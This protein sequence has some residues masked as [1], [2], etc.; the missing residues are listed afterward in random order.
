MKDIGEKC[1]N[2]SM[3]GRI[4]EQKVIGYKDITRLPFFY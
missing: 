3:E 1:K 2:E 4:E